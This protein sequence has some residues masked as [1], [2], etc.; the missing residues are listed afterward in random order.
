MLKIS[1]QFKALVAKHHVEFKITGF[2]LYML[3][4]HFLGKTDAGS[5]IGVILKLLGV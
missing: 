3:L 2:A 4:E 5:A 1:D